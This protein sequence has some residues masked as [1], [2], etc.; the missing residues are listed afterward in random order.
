[1]RSKP[2]KYALRSLLSCAMCGTASGHSYSTSQWCISGLVAWHHARVAARAAILRRRRRRR[3]RGRFRR[4]R[5]RRTHCLQRLLRDRHVSF[6][7]IYVLCTSTYLW[8]LRQ[9]SIFFYLD[10]SLFLSS[11]SAGDSTQLDNKI[12]ER[13]SFILK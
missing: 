7:W 8:A 9:W 13:I 2:Y 6:H 12:N 1:M 11:S 3:C 5:R 4:H 10:Q